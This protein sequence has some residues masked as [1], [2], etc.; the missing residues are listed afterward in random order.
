MADKEQ[1]ARDTAALAAA[2]NLQLGLEGAQRPLYITASS[3]YLRTEETS[4]AWL[5]PEPIICIGLAYNQLTPA[6]LRTVSSLSYEDGAHMGKYFYLLE[7]LRAGK[8]NL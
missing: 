8:G 7:T 6:Q 1:E 4:Y 3:P 5:G 2:A